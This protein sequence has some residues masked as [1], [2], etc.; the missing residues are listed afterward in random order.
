MKS[1]ALVC[2]AAG[3]A[4]GGAVIAAGQVPDRPAQPVPPV[5][6]G[7]GPLAAPSLYGTWNV[8]SAQESGRAL[9]LG[10]NATV[11]F[12]DGL[13]SW[14]QDG[15]R[16]ILK[17]EFADKGV[18]RASA[19]LP[20]TPGV[21]GTAATPSSDGSIP[22]AGANVGGSMTGVYILTPE[23]FCIALNVGRSGETLRT[24]PP[25]TAAGGPGGGPNSARPPAADIGIPQYPGFALILRK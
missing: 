24:A 25:T 4:V 13:L 16:R 2:L 11:D 5:P 6:A 17:L 20:G 22:G 8:V 9:D 3:L 1:I 19:V 7:P 14:D 12:R 23:F 18:L 10:R 15:R 21:R